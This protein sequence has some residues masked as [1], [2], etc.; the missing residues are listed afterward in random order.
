M[1]WARSAL[2]VQAERSR[3]VIEAHDL[4]EMG[5]PGPDWDCADPAMLEP[6]PFQL[7]QEYARHLGHLGHL[8]HLDIVAAR[9]RAVRGIGKAQTSQAPVGRVVLSRSN[10]LNCRV[11]PELVRASALN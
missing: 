1:S 6:I 8:G 7:V 11:P 2:R 5:K 3:A 4:A 9:Q 10:I